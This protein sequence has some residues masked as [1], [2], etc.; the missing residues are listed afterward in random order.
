MPYG[1][2]YMS[3]NRGRQW[4]QVLEERS[5]EWVTEESCA[6]GV[7]GVAYFVAGASKVTN[8]QPH[9]DLGTTHI[10]VSH[11]SGRT[12]ELGVTT[13][14]ADW[15][16]SIVD[17]TPGPNQNRL[18]LFFNSL[19]P[20]YSSLGE[21]DAAR[22]ETAGAGTRIGLL[23]YRDGDS[24]VSGP[25]TS[26][27]MAVEG[28]SDAFPGPAILLKS[29]SILTVVSGSRFRQ[30]GR[31][32]TVIESVWTNAT[33]TALERPSKVVSHTEDIETVYD[34]GETKCHQDYLTAGLAYD[35]TRN[36]LYFLYPEQRNTDCQLWL[37]MSEDEGA[38]WSD[39]RRVY[40]PD[41]DADRAYTNPAMAVNEGGVLGVMWEER[42]ASGCWMFAASTDAGATLSRAS[43]LGR[44]HM[45][46]PSLGVNS[47]ETFVNRDARDPANGTTIAIDNALLTVWR[48]TNAIAVA[49]IGSFYPTWIDGYRGN[50]ELRVAEVDVL[51]A[52]AMVAAETQGLRATSDQLAVLYGG[53]QSYDLTTR[54][55]TLQVVIRNV[56]GRLLKGPFKLA[57]THFTDTGCARIANA[58]NGAWFAGAV[59]DL[60]ETIPS[61]VLRPGETS[62]P[63]TLKFRLES[64]KK[65]ECRA[66]GIIGMTVKIFAAQDA[67]IE[68]AGQ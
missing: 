2:V 57:V 50:E 61:K 7:H 49:P 15:S 68:P 60:T 21:V 38:T 9:H 6:Y 42:R 52:E 62:S 33:R 65:P 4:K 32:E 5:S 48:N 67:T 19:A 40:S 28:L 51:S 64:S 3:P 39:P 46:A 29:G 18:Y 34:V 1:F 20:F 31:R 14:W 16:S 10:Y 25:Y 27:D 17:P 45:T 30:K 63:D 23:S 12:W 59:W 26:K 56:G 37:T 43:R 22:S 54:T 66:P 24:S 44:C 41:A 13:G 35:R 11:D 36:R 55:L 53:R 58:N 8:A 47:W